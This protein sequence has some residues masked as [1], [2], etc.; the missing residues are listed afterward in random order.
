MK[1]KVEL[2]HCER[3]RMKVPEKECAANLGVQLYPNPMSPF[4]FT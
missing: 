2:V 4:Y 3:E 1:G